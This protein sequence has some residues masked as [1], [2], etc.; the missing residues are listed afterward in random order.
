MSTWRDISI[1]NE[2]AAKHLLRAGRFRSAVSRAYYALYAAVAGELKVQGLVFGGGRDNPAHADLPT[3]LESNVAGFAQWERRDLK[4]AA[5]LLYERRL[6]ADYRESTPVGARTARESVVT[7]D[8]ALT[9]LR[10]KGGL[11]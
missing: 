1:D 8:W 9:M 6:D 11:A 4:A 3:L 10:S 2:L 5:R 7:M